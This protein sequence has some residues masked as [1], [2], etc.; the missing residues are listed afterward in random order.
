MDFTFGIITSPS[1]ESNYYVSEVIA[2]I[3]RQGIPP[4]K[5]EIIVV[6]GE[7][8]ELMQAMTNFA[9]HVGSVRHISFDESIK[10]GWITRKKNII[11]EKA[12]HDNIVFMHDYVM[13]GDGWYQEFLKFGNDWDICMNAV[14]NSNLKRYRDW[15]TF[16]HP[17]IDPTNRQVV[18]HPVSWTQHEPWCPDGREVNGGGTLM[19]YDY[20]GKHMYISGTY[21]VAK[22][23]VMEAEPLNEDLYHCESED[24]EWSLRVRDKYKYVMNE[25]SKVHLLRYKVL[26]EAWT[27]LLYFL[28]ENNDKSNNF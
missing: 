26:D 20:N 8:G 9:T 4:E 22:K 5:A 1:V 12:R 15:I 17:N 14:I 21:W 7:Y 16:D 25:M 11:A 6:G 23:H 27:R 19:P 13:L 3:Y 18:N 28:K 10:K 24:V 2:S